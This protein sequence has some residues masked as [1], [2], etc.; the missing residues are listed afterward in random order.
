MKMISLDKLFEVKNGNGLELNRLEITSRKDGLPF[1]SR[2]TGDNG[3]AAYVRPIKGVEP[4]DGGQLTCAL[5]GSGI[6]STF[7]QDDPFYTAYHVACLK[8]LRQFSTAELLYYCQCIEANRY[9]YSWGRQAN[10]TIKTLK[11]PEPSEMP[12]WVHKVNT[13]IYVGADR[14]ALNIQTPELF[15]HKWKRFVLSDLFDIKKGK[16]LTKANMTPGDVPFIGASENKNGV[17]AYIGKSPEHDANTITVPYNGN[18]VAEAFYQ[19]FPFCATDDV[20]VL[21]PKF[22][23]SP[24][25]ALFLTTMIRY[26][27][28][29]FSYGRKWHLERMKRST[30]SLPVT[31]G[32]TPDWELMTN[33]IESLPYS[34]LIA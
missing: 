27:K 17:T 30:I 3:I 22:E 5:S 7:I 14:P 34:S 12:D 11:I 29:R 9:K 10:R 25:I 16:R 18:S 28:Y 4:F 8:P 31:K 21:Y 2:K 1:V 24:P 20:N 19:P 23:L 32:G 13:D 26:E 6:L 33:L 15:T